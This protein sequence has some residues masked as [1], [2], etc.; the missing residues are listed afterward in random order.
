MNGFWEHDGA[1]KE[2]ETVW[3]V[4][5]LFIKL[6]EKQG[7]A[8]N[9]L[10]ELSAHRFLEQMGETLTVVE[11]RERL[12]KIDIDNNKRVALSEYL[13]TR[14]NKGVDALVA[15]PQGSGNQAEIKAAEDRLAVVADSL[16]K[17]LAAEEKVRL[18]EAANKAAVDDLKAQEDAYRTQCEALEAKSTDAKLGAVQKNKAANEL[19][20]LKA[21]DSLPLQKAKLT[22]E[23]SLRAVQRERK[24]AEAATAICEARVD[25]AKQALNELKQNGGV[26]QGQMWWLERELTEAQKFMPQ[27]KRRA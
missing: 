18:A 22:Q 8:G 4:T 9:E 5:Q 20:Q 26:P 24:A 10:D 27:S 14:Y 16:A 21:K 6:D 15:A 19:A 13:L 3:T 23:A 11:M 2:A 1:A 17:Q 12:R 25:E 7:K